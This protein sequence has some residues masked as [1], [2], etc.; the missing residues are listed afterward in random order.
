MRNY[1]YTPYSMA[2]IF[3]MNYLKGITNKAN[4]IGNRSISYETINKNALVNIFNEFGY[5]FVN[6]SLFDLQINRV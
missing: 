5:D 1:N 3:D 6:L 4:D 2:S